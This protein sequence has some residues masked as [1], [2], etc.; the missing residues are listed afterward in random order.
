M[1]D[2]MNIGGAFMEMTTRLMPDPAKLTTAQMA[3]WKDYLGLWENTARRMMGG[4]SP[5]WQRRKRT[6]AASRMPPGKRMRPP[7]S[8]TVLPSDLSLGAL[9]GRGR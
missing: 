8:S 4:T 6:T 9:D 7:T 3:L 2:P 5:P 1:A